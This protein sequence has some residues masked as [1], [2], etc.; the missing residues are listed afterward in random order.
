MQVLAIFG[1]WLALWA[2]ITLVD[3]A[4]GADQPK[5]WKAWQD[6]ATGSLVIALIGGVITTWLTH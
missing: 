4:P 6:K 1:C 2:I 5:S 3:L